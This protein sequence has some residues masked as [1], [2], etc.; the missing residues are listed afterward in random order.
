LVSEDKDTPF[1]F[2]LVIVE[3]PASNKTVN[4]ENNSFL[5]LVLPCLN[6]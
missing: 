5:I 1:V 2:A 6:V 3:V 4:S